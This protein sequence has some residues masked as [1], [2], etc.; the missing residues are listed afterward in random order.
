MTAGTQA[1][2]ARNMT[3]HTP[4]KDRIGTYGCSCTSS[5]AAPSHR[6]DMLR[7]PSGLECLRRPAEALPRP[8]HHAMACPTAGTPPVHRL[9]QS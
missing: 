6:L 3:H 7:R 1:S 8:W 5:V 9:F 2:S 4:E